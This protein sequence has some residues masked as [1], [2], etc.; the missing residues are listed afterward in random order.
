MQVNLAE[1]FLILGEVVVQGQEQS[2]GM[3]GSHHYARCHFGLGSARSQAQE[4]EH[5]FRTGVGDDGQIG[6]NAVFYIGSD[7]NLYFFVVG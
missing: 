5:E 6:V 1:R 4:V 7:I 2:F 3:F